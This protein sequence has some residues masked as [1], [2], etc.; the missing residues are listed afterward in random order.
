MRG[1]PA[2]LVDA[3]AR[4]RRDA[5]ARAFP[6]GA[7][8]RGV[9]PRDH[10][11]GAAARRRGDARRSPEPRTPARRSRTS[12]RSSKRS[13][14]IA[15]RTGRWWRPR[16]SRRCWCRCGAARD[17]ALAGLAPGDVLRGGGARDRWRRSTP[18]SRRSAAATPVDVRPGTWRSR[19]ASSGSACPRRSPWR[20]WRAG[21]PAARAA[22]RGCSTTWRWRSSST[23]TSSTG[24]TTWPRG[25]AWAAS[26]AGALRDAPPAAT[27]ARVLASGVLARMLASSARRFRAARRRGALLGAHRLARLGPRARGAHPR[28]RAARGAEPRLRQPLPR[29]LDMGADG[30][31]VSA[32]RPPWDFGY[33]PASPASSAPEDTRELVRRHAGRS[34]SGARR[35]RGGWDR[36]H[37]AVARAALLDPGHPRPCVVPVVAGRAAPGGGPRDSLRRFGRAPEPRAGPAARLRLRL[38]GPRSGLAPASSGCDPRAR[39][40]ARGL[41]PPPRGGRRGRRLGALRRRRRHSSRGHRRRRPR[42]RVSRPRRGG[43]HRRRPAAPRTAPTAR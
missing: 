1:L 4:A 18:S 38:P 23:T 21:T 11:G 20:R 42:G 27:K 37:A 5:G 16:S 26:L 2:A 41:V 31:R 17:A 32:A 8:E 10:P 29:A 36:D 34:R 43:A 15:W 19:T 28:P 35:R 25:G 39:G 3:C 12:W 24:R 14:P 9:L 13:A 7:L 33:A 40:H 22:S 6:R 30:A